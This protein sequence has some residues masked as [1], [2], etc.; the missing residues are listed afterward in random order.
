LPRRHFFIPVVVLLATAF[1]CV[2]HRST[3]TAGR[4][5]RD[6]GPEPSDWF[7]MQRAFPF[8]TIPQ[9]KLEAA[10]DE[11][12]LARVEQGLA[13]ESIPLTWTP[14]GPYNIGGRVTAIAAVPGTSTAYMGAANGGVFKSTNS[15]T[16]WTPV[17]DDWGVY[18][19][20]ALALS[21]SDPNVVYVGTGE[22]NSS[23]DSYDGAGVFRSMDGGATWQS[24]GLETTGRIGRVA[25][26]PS[27]TKRIFVAAMGRQFSTGPDRGLYRSEDGGLDWTR[28]LFVDDSTGVSD[29]AINPAHPET[30][31]CA[32]W[33]RVRR[34]SYRRA[35]GP[36][37][38]I[39]R[40]AD[41]GLTWTRL[42]AGLPAPSDNVGR[43]GLAI[44]PSRPSTIYAQITTG[45]SDGYQGLGV[46]RSIDGGATWT[47]RDVGSTYSGNFGGFSWY[48]GECG[49]DPANPD[50]VYSL[51][52]SPLRS[53]DGGVTFTSIAGGAHVDQHALWIDPT[54]PSRLMLGNDG[55]FYVS[56]SGGSAW[57]KSLDLP[58]SQFYAGAI[59]PSNPA[60]LLGGTQ[61]NSTVQT[62]GSP[63][64]WG[65]ILGG[66]GFVCLVDP[67]N[68]NLVLG[69]YQFGCYGAGPQRSTNG[70]ASWTSPTGI[71]S[72]DRFNWCT[73]ITMDP[74]NHMVVLCASQRVYRSTDNGLSYAPISGD[75]STNPPAE[76]TY[77]SVTTLD[78]SPLD[79]RIYF[80]GTDDG[81]VWRTVDSGLTWTDI[82]AGLPLRWVTRVAADP[83]DAQGVYV[84]LSG[85]GLDEHLAHVFRSGDRGTTWTSIASNLPDAPAN[86]L[87][88][89]PSDAQTLYL[90]TDVGVWVTRDRGARWYPLGNGL[91]VQAVFDLTLHPASRSLVAATHGRSQWRLDLTPA[92]L[93]V[94]EPSATMR[95]S[96]PA[97]NPSRETAHLSLELPRASSVDV[98]VYDAS[99]RR[100]R[101]LIRDRLASGR[102]AIAWD[103]RDAR[104][105]RSGAGVFFLRATE[106]GMAAVRRIVR[107]D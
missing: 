5:E 80:A 37:C 77:G 48:F 96:A 66:D 99:G 97:P 51:G 35:F 62:S 63:S 70:G 65:V 57:T 17:F 32:T 79:S 93:A 85:F 19:I 98:S 87:V 102:H 88:P 72:G 74:G 39:W 49:V 73:P 33:E 21:P 10:L 34:P 86:D 6:G 7:G 105:A 90:A 22:S 23:V 30:V 92:P 60:R 54:N 107:V 68:P 46:Y 47:R 3:P 103:G 40:S 52:L 56:T 13:I 45:A 31:F 76:L 82:T 20:G 94:A 55:G 44:A 1:L 64:A 91:P 100:V 15:G 67:T 27:Q 75:L 36:G 50:R 69:E 61:D 12:R 106:G 26:D 29:V 59:D 43:I 4:P 38:G 71:N 11:T 18:S 89:D 24:L 95:L 28:V 9:G 58:I 16:N 2:D 78:I 42:S 81:K 14:A 83:W 84:T 53:D 25:I 41:H 104:G 101:N 8:A